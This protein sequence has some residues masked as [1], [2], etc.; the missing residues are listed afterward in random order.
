MLVWYEGWENMLFCRD[1]FHVGKPFLGQTPWLRPG[2]VL[3]LACL[4]MA[5]MSCQAQQ[6][7]ELETA[8]PPA[9]PAQPDAS[10]TAQPATPPPTPEVSAT[11]AV[12]GELDA[13]AFLVAHI[14]GYG[15]DLEQ[16]ADRYTAAL[17]K[18]PSN[19]TLLEW[20]FRMLYVI[21]QI[22]RAAAIASRIDQ[23]GQPMEMG[24]EPAAAIAARNQD[25]D[26]LD[27]LANHLWADRASQPLGIVFSAWSLAFRG[28]GDAGLSRLLDLD[29]LNHGDVKP[30]ILAQSALMAEYLHHPADAL[31]YASDVLK[32]N[33][34]PIASR[35][36]M[37][38]VL[39]RNGEIDAAANWLDATLG[40]IFDKT[41][42]RRKL[43]EGEISLMQPPSA[44]MLL[45]N[46]LIEAGLLDDS[47]RI[48]LLARLHLAGYLDPLYDRLVYMMGREL[49]ELN[50]PEDAMAWIDQMPRDSLW[51]QPA[52]ILKAQYLSRTPEGA[53]TA[54]LIY[55]GLLQN[56]PANISLWQQSADN[57]RWNGDYASALGKYDTALAL[58][59]T[60]GRLHYHR[61]IC[62]DHLGREDEAEA[63]FRQAIAL[64]PDDSYALNYFGYWLLEMGKAP[65]EALLL[66][67]KAVEQ[68]PDN[69]YFID[70]LGWGYYKLGQYE[71]AVLYLEKAMTIHP[72]DPVISDHLGDAYV[73][74]GRLREAVFHWER[75]LLYAHDDTDTATI[76]QKI[77]AAKTQETP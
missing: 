2:A 70:S 26:G 58:F 14:A 71:K 30:V 40:P 15:R 18:D 34:A 38:G 29:L 48:H 54:A 65:E 4:A 39:A 67:Y 53:E 43:Q 41:D 5:V 17:A 75:A 73:A 23:L 44:Q 57:D 25:W 46:A 52:L 28:Q 27:V 8:R 32:N 50:Y 62:L 7:A 60:S 36:I 56:D 45:A 61:G 10:A 21:G 51:L 11:P 22:D 66:I 37:A 76:R 6:T 74:L 35:I 69:G 13:G 64:D 72:I 68:Q 33:S 59:P 42:L 16:A 49:F 47:K 3:L 24:S 19:F 20:S 9:A 31:S 1:M 12:D 55:D 63:A 77:R